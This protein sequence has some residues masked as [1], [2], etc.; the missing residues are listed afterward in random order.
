[1]TSTAAARFIDD[2]RRVGWNSLRPDKDELSDLP[3]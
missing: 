2:I 1:M 3:F